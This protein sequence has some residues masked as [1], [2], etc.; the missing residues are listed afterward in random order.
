MDW[1]DLKVDEIIGRDLVEKD[2]LTHRQWRGPIASANLDGEIADFARSWT[3]ISEDDG[4]T[5]Q[6]C[7][8]VPAML[9]K[10]Q[11]LVSPLIGGKIMLGVPQ[12]GMS[13]AIMPLNDNLAKPN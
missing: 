10:N 11:N 7:E 12:V 8:D 9:A 4:K 3:A 5:W 1:G 13:F 6:L 2:A